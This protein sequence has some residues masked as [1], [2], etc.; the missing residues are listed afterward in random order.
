MRQGHIKWTKCAELPVGMFQAQGVYLRKKIYIGGGNTGNSD[1]DTLIFEYDFK[2]N[3]WTALPPVESVYFG[4][5]KLEGEL[6]AVG[7]KVETEAVST[8]FVF[9]SFTKR[10]KNSLPSMS[11]ARYSPSCAS[12]QSGVIVIGGLSS[13]NDLLSSNSQPRLYRSSP[14][15]HL[16]HWRLPVLDGQQLL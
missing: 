12:C 16:P 13:R 7:G 11:V 10:W 15:H 8:V 14:R 3:S 9:D 4:L 2:T 5:C 6:V 1:T